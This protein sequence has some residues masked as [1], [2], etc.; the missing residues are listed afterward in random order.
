MSQAL[1]EEVILMLVQILISTQ[2]KWNVWNQFLQLQ[3]APVV[4]TETRPMIKSDH[5]QLTRSHH[6]DK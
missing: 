6:Q 4:E 5:H 3:M 2:K 1:H